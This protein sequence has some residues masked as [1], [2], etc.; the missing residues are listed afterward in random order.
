MYP[1]QPTS[2]VLL[3]CVVHICACTVLHS[4]WWKHKEAANG[5]DVTTSVAQ[6]NENVTLDV[7]SICRDKGNCSVETTR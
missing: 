2:T 3:Y 4:V 7:T 1:D 6:D 5:E